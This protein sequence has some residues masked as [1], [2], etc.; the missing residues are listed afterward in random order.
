MDFARQIKE[1]VDIVAVVSERVPK[2]RRNGTRWVAPCPFHQEKTPSFGVNPQLRIFKCFGC[3]AGGSV[4]DFIMQ[5]DGLTFWEACKYLAE[6]FGIPLPVRG[7]ESDAKT[8]LRAGIFE[9]HEMA[10]QMFRSALGS[11][12]GAASRDYLKRRGVTQ[13]LAEEFG[14]GYSDRGGQMLTRR[15]QQAGWTPEQMES[16]GLVSRRDD[17][18]FYDRFRG[19]LMYPIQN[20]QGKIIAFAGRAL[21]D[22][23]QPKYLNS[24]ETELYHKRAV[25]YNLHRARKPIHDQGHAI[26]VE[27]YMDVIG[28]AGGAVGEAVASCGTALVDAQ[29]SMLSRHTE[30]V[31]VNF[32]PDTA[33]ANATER[34][35]QLLLAEGLHIRVLALPEDLDPDEF[36]QAHGADA[37][38]KLLAEAPRYFHWLADRA[39]ERFDMRDAEGKVEA[40]RFLLPSIQRL[41]DKY[42]RAAVAT[43]LAHQLG[44]DKALLLDQVRG[45]ARREE[46][47]PR[48]PELPATERLLIRELVSNAEAR[49]QLLGRIGSADLDLT[50][51]ARAILRAIAAAGDIAGGQFDYDAVSARLGETERA[52]LTTLV[53]ADE[54]TNGDHSARYEGSSGIEQAAACVEALEKAG[55]DSRITELK[56]NIKEAEQGGN[57]E[58]AIRLSEQLRQTEGQRKHQR[59]RRGIE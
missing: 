16:T 58:E 55:M 38:R 49:R 43:E 51:G 34:S 14:L 39:R 2:L 47:R 12:A 28:L 52:L 19:R 42:E 15:M 37:Y 7:A 27:G 1:S 32:D 5:L 50:D 11:A 41:R 22:D 6:R 3:Q 56:K 59:R 48:G 18:S 54:G 21:N 30:R 13:K 24:P 26:L 23:D 31:V 57:F 53:F 35:L 36:V 9:A 25:L 29:V 45:T 46:P 4:I 40:V 10:Q 20:E 8:K 44:I 17:G 33:G